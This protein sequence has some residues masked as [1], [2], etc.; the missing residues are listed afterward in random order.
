MID[1][2]GQQAARQGKNRKKFVFVQI[3]SAR[4]LLTA[5]GLTCDR[6]GIGSGRRA[7]LGS[8]LPPNLLEASGSQPIAAIETTESL[9]REAAIEA[10]TAT[11]GAETTTEA[12]GETA[13]PATEAEGSKTSL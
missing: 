1:S 4:P 2:G 8:C 13:E 11:E 7:P 12:T 5:T 10:G 3:S 6:I 9:S